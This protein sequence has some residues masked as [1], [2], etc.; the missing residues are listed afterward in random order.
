MKQQAYTFR[1]AVTA[2]QIYRNIYS[3]GKEQKSFDDRKELAAWKPI[4][5]KSGYVLNNQLYL[6]ESIVAEADFKNCALLTIEDNNSDVHHT[7][8]HIYPKKINQCFQRSRHLKLDIFKLE[9]KDAIDM[10]LDYGYFE[11]GTPERANFKLC[12]LQPQEPVEIKINGKTDASLSSRRERTFKEQHYIYENLG[13]FQQYFLLKETAEPV[14]KKVPSCSNS[15]NLLKP[16][17]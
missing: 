7:L 9:I 8:H 17:W 10:H 5:S 15:I 11:V 3:Y 13:L 12:T 1:H 14:I 4:V 16:L 2:L 6:P